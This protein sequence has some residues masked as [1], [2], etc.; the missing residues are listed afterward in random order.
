MTM[1]KKDDPFK[2]VIVGAGGAGKTC[3]VHMYMFRKF[4]VEYEPTTADSFR[5]VLQLDGKNCQVDI[6]DT[7]GQ[8]EIM[9]DN[10][11]K[12]GE[13][14]M[15]VFDINT[16]SSFDNMQSF[17]DQITRV[18][19]TEDIPMVLVGNK[20]D[21]SDKR[22]VSTAQGQQMADKFGCRYYETS[23]KDNLNVDQVFLD[24]VKKVKGER[25]LLYPKRRM[26]VII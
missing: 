11:Y 24:L 3:L 10:Y 12:T 9:R 23:V 22:E 14:F 18:K 1:K 7:A 26:C 25:D 6:L 16:K 19:E 5:K 17:Y 21:L 8:E 13:G 4:L 15:L 2:V 20:S